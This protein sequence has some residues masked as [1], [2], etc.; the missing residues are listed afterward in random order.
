MLILDM[1]NVGEKE[2]ATAAKSTAPRQLVCVSVAQSAE[3]FRWVW[4]SDLLS[5]SPDAPLRSLKWRNHQRTLQRE[6]SESVELTQDGLDRPSV[7]FLTSLPHAGQLQHFGKKTHVPPGNFC[8]STTTWKEKK[9]SP[10]T[11]IVGK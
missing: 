6:R 9:R 5:S 7:F 3:V 10:C 2:K 4:V 8:N 1:L 11:L